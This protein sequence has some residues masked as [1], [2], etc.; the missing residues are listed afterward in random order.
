MYYTWQELSRMINGGNVSL[1]NPYKKS[2]MSSTTYIGKVYLND[3]HRRGI[4][5]LIEW[6]EGSML[7]RYMVVSDTGSKISSDDIVE[8]LKEILYE[9]WYSPEQ[10]KLLNE[11]REQH[12]HHHSSKPLDMMDIKK[13]WKSNYW[14]IIMI[15]EIN[16]YKDEYRFL[17][18]SYG[19]SIGRDV[20]FYLEASRWDLN[21]FELRNN[22]D[23]QYILIRKNTMELPYTVMD[24]MQDELSRFTYKF[25]TNYPV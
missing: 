20:M 4:I 1:N 10:K 5:K 7:G 21:T 3:E 14:S 18:R 13:L 19:L 12:K 9:G 25:T 11:L 23:D 2:I 15:D 16:K 8:T 17:L 22:I 6:L 24:S